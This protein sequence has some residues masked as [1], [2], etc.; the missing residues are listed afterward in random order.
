MADFLNL[1]VKMEPLTFTIKVFSVGPSTGG[2][3]TSF[4]VQ[5]VYVLGVCP[6]AGG[7]CPDTYSN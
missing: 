3:G 4:F 5:R 7:L 6:G 1:Q 2:F